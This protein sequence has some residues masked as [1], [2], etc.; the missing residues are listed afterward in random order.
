MHFSL[1]LCLNTFYFC[2]SRQDSATSIFKSDINSIVHSCYCQCSNTNTAFVFGGKSKHQIL[3]MCICASV[4][5]QAGIRSLH[6]Y[7]LA[8][9]CSY[10]DHQLDGLQWWGRFVL[11]FCLFLNG[12]IARETWSFVFTLS[13]RKLVRLQYWMPN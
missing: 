6:H 2:F 4:L 3:V 10:Q 9:A 11:F 5:K 8:V 13:I 1:L 7:Q 12:R